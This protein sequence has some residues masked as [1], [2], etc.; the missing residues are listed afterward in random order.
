MRK[1]D[2]AIKNAKF[3]G[4]ISIMRSITGVQVSYARKG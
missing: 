4:I 1:S 2:N 3:L